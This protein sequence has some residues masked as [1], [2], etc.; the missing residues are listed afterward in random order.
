MPDDLYERDILSWAEQQ[1]ALLR[2]LAKGERLNAAVDW[3]HVIEELED[4]G[5]AELRACDSLLRQALVHLLKLH[6]HPDGPAAHWRAEMLG[7][8]ADAEARFTPSIRQRIN[9]DTLYRKALNQIRAAE[10]EEASRALP[11]TCPFALEDLLADEVDVTG[12]IARLG[13]SRS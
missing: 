7:S 3:P 11:R 13:Q 12:L 5:L 2:G 8:L 9:L 1:A 4:V 6:S 10:G